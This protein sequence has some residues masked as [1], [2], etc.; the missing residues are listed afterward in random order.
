MSRSRLS[1]STVVWNTSMDTSLPSANTARVVPA[2]DSARVAIR[3]GGSVRNPVKP[4]SM[5]PSTWSACPRAPRTSTRITASRLDVTIPDII[6]ASP[7]D[8]PPPCRR[9]NSPPAGYRAQHQGSSPSPASGRR[10]HWCPFHTGQ[11]QYRGRGICPCGSPPPG[12]VSVGHT[13]PAHVGQS[14]HCYNVHG[15]REPPPFLT[16]RRDVA[17]SAHYAR[18]PAGDRL[19]RPESTLQHLIHRFGA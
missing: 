1:H 17:T 7:S 9:W 14:P 2:N 6:R 16:A 15:A 5:T 13:T 4:V 11:S 19:A 10:L 18:P 8:F 12:H 3:R